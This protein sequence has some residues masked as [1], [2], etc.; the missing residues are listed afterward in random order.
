LIDVRDL[1]ERLRQ[2][3]TQDVAGNESFLSLEEV[4]RRHVLRVLDSVGGNKA[5][6]AE[7]LGIGRATIYQLL[8]RMKP[9]ENKREQHAS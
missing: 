9:E 2:P 7:I 4:Q 8:S 6:A 1:P 5:R 3:L